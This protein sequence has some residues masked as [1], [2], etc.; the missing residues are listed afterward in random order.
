LEAELQNTQKEITELHNQRKKLVRE[1]VK[2][3]IGAKRE[4]ALSNRIEAIDKSTRELQIRRNTIEVALNALR[5]LK[6]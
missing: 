6:K 4:K 3:F 1:S 2:L 5:V